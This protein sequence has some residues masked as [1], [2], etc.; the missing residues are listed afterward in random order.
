MSNL[1]NE[2]KEICDY[3]WSKIKRGQFFKLAM[4]MDSPDLYVL[5]MVQVYHYTK[6]NSLNQASAVFPESYK[7]I[8]LIHFAL[9]HAMEELGHENMAAHDLKSLGINEDVLKSPPLP[10][11]AA[12]SGYLDSVAMK[13]GVAA[14]LGYSFWAEDSYEHLQPL[15]EVCKSRLGLR[16]DQMTFFIAHA[17]IDAQHAK[18]VEMAIT[19]W[20]TSD[21][22]RENIKQVARV[23][24]NL[25]GKILEDVAEQYLER[26]SNDNA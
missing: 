13:L 15:L 11:T 23:T 1:I 5:A 6:Y 17:E 26:Q 14:R 20:V 18:E 3:E 22:D 16:D 10:A 7:N 19:K 2:L 9:K 12:L 24:L 4:E 21:I 8:G 25:T